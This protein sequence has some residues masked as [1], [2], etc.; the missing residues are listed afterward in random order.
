MNS[1]IV[2]HI[3]GYHLILFKSQRACAVL[4]KSIEAIHN[5]PFGAI[6]DNEVVGVATVFET[7][8]IFRV[9]MEGF[10]IIAAYLLISDGAESMTC[11]IS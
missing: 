8:T 6:F 11:F 1:A 2:V 10:H 7:D 5:L 3:A 4:F 9:T